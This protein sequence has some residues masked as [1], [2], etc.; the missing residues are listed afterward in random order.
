MKKQ[1]FASDEPIAKGFHMF[2]V[3]NGRTLNVDEVSDDNVTVIP[4]A[5][6]GG[7]GGFARGM[8]AALDIDATHVLLMDDD[9][10][11]MPESFIRTFNLLSLRNDDYENAFING[12]MLS[13]E[14]PQSPIRGRRTRPK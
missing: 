14:A 13:L 4:N 7:A 10:R 3:D 6:V 12:A 2:V 1:I 11:V 5:N 8:M 9:V